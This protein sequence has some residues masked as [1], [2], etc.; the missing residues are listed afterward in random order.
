MTAAKE[1]RQPDAAT[2]DTGTK[3]GHGHRVT[4]TWKTIHQWNYQGRT[5]R[6]QI[7]AEV[8]GWERIVV[9]KFTG[10]EIVARWSR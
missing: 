7:H 6:H 4:G 1:A 10:R 8:P 5:Y 3:S 9:G 2:E